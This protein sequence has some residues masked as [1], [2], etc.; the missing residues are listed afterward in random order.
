MSEIPWDVVIPNL[1]WIATLITLIGVAYKMGRWTKGI[2]EKFKKI[3][4]NPFI[5]A[6]N[7]LTAKVVSDLLYQNFEKYQKGN[8]LT[9]EEIRQRRELTDRLDARVITPDEARILHGILNKEL[10]EAR[11]AGNFLAVLA[12]LFLIGLVIGVLAS[13]TS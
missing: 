9:A 11:A 5:V 12:I 6:T 8:P 2:E 10:Q 3:E 1:G 13:Q 7:K 4:E